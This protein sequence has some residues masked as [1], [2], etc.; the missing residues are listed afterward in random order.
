MVDSHRRLN[1]TMCLALVVLCAG[2]IA[3]VSPGTLGAGATGSAL[4]SGPFSVT[5]RDSGLVG[6]L[7]WEVNVF[8]ASGSLVLSLATVNPSEVALLTAGVYTY[9]ASGPTGWSPV[10]T[11]PVAFSV[12]R[13][14]GI[15][16]PF[17]L[18]PGFG[19]FIFHERG[20]A[21]GTNWSV[22]V[23]WTG[24]S[25]TGTPPPMNATVFSSGP[26]LRIA[27]WVGAMYQYHVSTIP[28]YAGPSYMTGDLRG[29]THPESLPIT[30]WAK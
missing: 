18:A 2:G 19:V 12:H 28:G 17:R 6:G 14:V 5:F 27:V 13:A 30:Y 3:L 29:A 15:V 26:I 22:T 23:N 11:H 9:T 20:L 16:V 24:N 8:N 7:P 25:N 21:R 1:A 10:R 4:S